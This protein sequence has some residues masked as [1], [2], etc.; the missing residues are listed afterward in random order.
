MNRKRSSV[1]GFS[2]DYGLWA[3]VGALSHLIFTLCY[4]FSDAIHV[5]FIQRYPLAREMPSSNGLLALMDLNETLVWGFCAVQTW[6]LYRH[7]QTNA[8]SW[9]FEAKCIMGLFFAVQVLLFG[10]LGFHPFAKQP[11][12]R[13][14]GYLGI[15][16]IDAVD[17]LGIIGDFSVYARYVPQVSCNWTVQSTVG[18]SFLLIVLDLF[19]AFFA[20]LEVIPQRVADRPTNERNRNRVVRAVRPS[21]L[22]YA[23]VFRFFWDLVLLYQH[24]IYKGKRPMVKRKYVKPVDIEVI[25]ADNEEGHR[26]LHG[27]REGEVEL[28]NM[29]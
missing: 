16:L 13:G 17:W 18:S 26:L 21:G 6:L 9:S 29:A 8:Q 14:V 2:L 22:F 20:I 4:L 5:Q 1:S 19:G 24:V 27:E 7:T 28:R 3:F 10:A 25:G 11:S 12:P 23:S 15:K